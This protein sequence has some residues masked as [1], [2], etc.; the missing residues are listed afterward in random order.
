M[1]IYQIT[2]DS[3]NTL[4][5]TT[6]A[7]AGINER[8]DLQ[9][10]FRDRIEIIAPDTLVIS[11]EFGYWDDSR[12]RIDL[13]AVDKEANLVVIELK[14]TDDGGHME[15]QA[16]RYAAMVSTITF[17]K[18]VDIL[19]EY[20]SQRGD[21]RDA[22][23]TLLD[24][25]EWDEPDEDAFA[26]EVRIV[27]AS[28]EFSKEITTAVLWL[29]EHGID[30]RCI[31]IK[32]YG[33]AGNVFLDVQQLIPLPEAEDY[34]VR[35]REKKQQERSARRFNPDL[36]KYTVTVGDRVHER[37]PKRHA[38]F[39]VVKAL[40][41]SGISPAEIKDVLDW[42]STLFYSAPGHLDSDAMLKSLAAQPASKYQPRRWF[43]ENDDLIHFDGQ[44]YCFSNQWGRH[45]AR[46]MQMLMDHFKPQDVSVKESI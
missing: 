35:V 43:T 17:A 18:A 20:L 41:E 38:I 39:T 45:T 23:K 19:S 1:A 27:L 2:N 22:N 7:S 11:E 30:I 42:R 12:R 44:T 32:P 6:F 36:T 31:R 16:I 25:L 40:C 26:S 5:Q 33:R 15:L 13:L 46:A 28:A 8:D 37:L 9:R 34:Q 3:I 4:P 21:T 10:F 14:R 29:A 24:F